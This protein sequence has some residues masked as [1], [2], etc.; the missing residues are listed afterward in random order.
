MGV[1]SAIDNVLQGA[2]E[3]GAVPGVI[4]MATDG[5]DVIYQG[6]FGARELAG[7]RPMQV[8]T[9]CWIH[10]MTKAVTAACVM[11][12][13]EQGRIGLDDDCGRW[14]KA[15][16]E[17][18]VLDGF[19]A[20]GQPRLRPARSPITLRGLL[21]HTAGFVYDTW[22]ADMARYMRVTGISRSA[23]FVRPEDCQPLAFDPGARWEYGI[24]IDW[25]GK[26]L[27][28]ITGETLDDY[29]QAHLLGPLGMTS[30]GYRL[31][32]EIRARLSGVHQRHPD[33]RLEAV[34]FEPPQQPGDFL[35]GGGMYS[36]AGDYTRFIMMILGGGALGGT[37]ILKPETVVEMSRNQIGSLAA[38]VLKSVRPEM[39]HDADFFP[40]MRCGW[41]LSFL[42]NPQDVPG[43]RAAGSLCWAGLRNSYFW[44]DPKRRIGGTI[45]TQLLP[46]ADPAVLALYGAF[47]TEVYRLAQRAV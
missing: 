24:G 33:G 15:L 18:K 8:D 5:H 7:A 21:T 1:G 44:I 46:F 40:G 10:S 47:E 35:G 9:V 31:R 6:A 23:S 41:G 25:A 27:E 16:S 3:S 38:G 2:V 39:S 30:T 29:M 12:L 43:R 14:L 13:V 19:D 34:P 26:A 20:A 22:N 42:I 32:P 17:P 37:R 4:A 36:T 45:I 11:Q 28:A